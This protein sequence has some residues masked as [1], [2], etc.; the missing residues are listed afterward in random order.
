MHKHKIMI[1]NIYKS[2][3]TTIIGVL[4]AIADIAYLFVKEQPDKSILVAMAVISGVFIF[5][6]DSRAKKILDKFTIK[7]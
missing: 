4:F 3:I 1:K 6:S 5:M 2:Y 7:L